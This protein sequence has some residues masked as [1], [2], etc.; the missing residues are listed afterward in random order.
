MKKKEVKNSKMSLD[1][2]AMMVANGFSGV[3]QRFDEVDKKL[4][5]VE[6]RLDRVEQRLNNVEQRL[7]VIT[8]KLSDH[9]HRISRV[10]RKTGIIK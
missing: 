9:R 3:E 10:E 1:K 6:N 5:G 2:L 4:D 8:D 7:D